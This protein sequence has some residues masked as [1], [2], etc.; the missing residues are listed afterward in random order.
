MM[1]STLGAPLGGTTRGGHQGFESLAL[2]LITPPN[3]GGTGGSCLPSMVVV[4][5]G[6][7]GSG[8][9]GWTG[10]F[11]SAPLPAWV[12]K[13]PM[14]SPPVQQPVGRAAGA[15]ATG[16]PSDSCAAPGA[17]SARQFHRKLPPAAP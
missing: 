6:E 3:F 11:G 5:S 9:A 2:S 15:E 7:P 14:S 12:S 13:T 4:A 8:A 17:A 1:S 16:R 10:A